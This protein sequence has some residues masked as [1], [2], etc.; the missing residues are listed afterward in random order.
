[1]PAVF[2]GEAVYS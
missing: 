2:N 1:M